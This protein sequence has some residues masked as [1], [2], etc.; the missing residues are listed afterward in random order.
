MIES[1]S[2]PLNIKLISWLPMLNIKEDILPIKMRI[3][4]IVRFLENNIALAIKTHI[5]ARIKMIELIE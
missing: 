2:Y 5:P 1:I 3:V 4:E